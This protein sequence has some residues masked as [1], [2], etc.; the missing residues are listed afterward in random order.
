M[1]EKEGR[2]RLECEIVNRDGGGRNWDGG[3]GCDG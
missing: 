1:L 3:V 2:E